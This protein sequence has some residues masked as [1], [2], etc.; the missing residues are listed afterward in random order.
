MWRMGLRPEAPRSKA[1]GGAGSL[2]LAST[3]RCR[4][5]T[6]SDGS[7]WGSGPRVKGTGC[8]A[9]WMCGP[10]RVTWKEEAK[11]VLLEDCVVSPDALVPSL[12]RLRGF[13]GRYEPHFVRSEQRELCTIYLEGLLSPLDRKSVE[14]IANAAGRPRRALQRFVGAG[15]WDDEA[16][17]REFRAHVVVL[18]HRRLG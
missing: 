12:E 11:G 1:L 8:L 15:K 10:D 13:V 7:V 17:S 2:A 4:R 6:V 18:E 14:P 16:V 9:S 3:A 5:Q